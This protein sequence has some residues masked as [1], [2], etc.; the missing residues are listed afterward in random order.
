MIGLIWLRH[1]KKYAKAIKR[2][3]NF[4]TY[5]DSLGARST[6]EEITVNERTR[7][8]SASLNVF[9]ASGLFIFDITL[10]AF[11]GY[12]ILPH[13]IYGII[14]FCALFN[15]TSSKRTR[16]LSLVSTL[17]FS[18]TSMLT[19]FYT[20]RFFESYTYIN[21]SFSKAAK[22]AYLMI[23]IFSVAELV[24]MLLMLTA[25]TLTLYSFI[26][27]HTDV[28]PNDPSYSETNRRNHLGTLK[29]TI[30]LFVLSA[31]IGILK[32][33][34]VFF[35]QT[36][37]VIYSEVNPEGITASKAPAT[38]TIIFLLCIIYVIYSLVAASNLK[39]EVR[40]KYDK[41]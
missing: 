1:A 28:A 33:V 17:G 8:L 40:F 29:R 11:G 32:C 3:G 38:D 36:Y 6:P 37:T 23:K 5:V 25:A 20:K 34:N 21:L 18:V 2:S 7:K 10:E 12:N 13:F 19:Y 15:L 24:F 9:G 14:M 30:P 35:K 26:K 16:I 4:A 31:V 27:E 41:F 22:K 39:D